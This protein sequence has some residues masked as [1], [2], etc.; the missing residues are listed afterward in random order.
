MPIRHFDIFLAERRLIQ[1]SAV[2]LL[3]DQKVG[4]DASYWLRKILPKETTV[5]ALGG[6]PLGLRTAIERE[7]ANFKK[8]RIH[9]VFVFQGLNMVRKDKPFSN[10]DNRPNRREA[11][12]DAYGHGRLDQALSTWASSGGVQQ[13]DMITYIMQILTENEVEFIRAPYSQWAQLSYMHSHPRHIVNRI[14][15]GSEMLI[16]DVDSVMIGIDFQKGNY[17]W[18]S[19]KTV[20]SDLGLSDEQ[21]LDV[22]ILAGFDYC[23]TFPPLNNN[24]IG[25]TFKGTYDLVKQH[26]TGF[27]AVQAYGDDPSVVK[28]HYIDTFCRTRCAV[29]YH[30]V[31]T[32]DGELRPLHPERAPSDIHEIIGY[33]LPDEIYYYVLSGMIGPQVINCL[34]SGVLIENAPLCNGETEE[35]RTFLQQ[36]L[37]IR[38]QT[39][40]LISQPMHKFYQ[41]RKVVTV[42]WFDPNEEHIMH[43]HPDHCHTDANVSHGPNS[44]A[45]ALNTVWEN[46]RAWSLTPEFLEEE[47]AKQKIS[48]VDVRFCLK[49]VEDAAQAAKTVGISNK[50]LESTDE[51]IAVVLSKM[52]EIRD[53]LTSKH[54]PTHWGT[55][56]TAAANESNQEALLS[57][58]ELIR[59][60]ILTSKEYSKSYDTPVQDDSAKHIRLISR[61]FSLVPMTFK[62]DVPFVGQMYRDVLVF[63]SFVK[64]LN[65]S[66]R[67]LCEMLLLSL[68]LNDCIKRDRRDYAELSF[69]L[70]YVSD[71]NAASG[72][73]AKA[74]LESTLKEESAAKALESTEKVYSTAIDLKAGL[75]NGF[76]FWDQVMKGIKVLK[77]AKSFENTCDMF[78]EADAWLQGRRLP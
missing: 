1:T 69:R 22:C 64:A 34:E 41:S 65:R 11:G 62:Q 12:W 26:K 51:V 36:L 10:P 66:Y 35:Y 37:N 32:D 13:S 49:A 9:P 20:L 6:F 18:L 15:G 5:V 30:L 27:N 75:T 4:I 76:E 60:D 17:T 19:K 55:A 45:S 68:F 50:T 63:N 58:F 23:P 74:Y 40:S 71:I 61:T 52:L 42:F 16:W 56:F 28:T 14:L 77:A 3:K 73:V 8:H 25:F 78:L 2:T 39:L 48:H 21:F 33:R 43:H 44:N 29:K 7:L 54:K 72:M 31:Y 47:K 59:F 46:T 57:A 67:N 70:P 24:M 38:T 53:F